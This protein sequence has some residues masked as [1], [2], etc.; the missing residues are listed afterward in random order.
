MYVYIINCHFKYL[1]HPVFQ[2]KK[3]IQNGSYCNRYE[4]YHRFSQKRES[5]CDI[6]SSLAR[7]ARMLRKYFSVALIAN[8]NQ[9]S[10][11]FMHFLKR[12]FFP[13]NKNDKQNFFYLNFLSSYI[14]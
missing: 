12:N 2:S 4:S 14:V 1:K 10:S 11:I 3:K 9:E 8:A 5:L 6:S 13:D 7:I